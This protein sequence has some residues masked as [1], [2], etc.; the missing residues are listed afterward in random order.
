[1]KNIDQ[2]IVEALRETS[3]K[4]AAGMILAEDVSSGD[5]VV[6][7][8][9]KGVGGFA[10]VKGKVVGS[11]DKGSGFAEVEFESGT[12]VHLEKSLLVKV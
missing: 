10:G 1:M 7:V 3:I 12:R 6:S 4:S 8:D 2:V 5:H 9:D 11:S